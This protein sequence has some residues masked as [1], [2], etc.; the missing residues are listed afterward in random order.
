VRGRVLAVQF[1][2][3]NLIG[4]LPMLFVGNLADVFGIPRVTVFVAAFV[5][6]F[7][8]MN[9]IWAIATYRDARQRHVP[10]DPQSTPTHLSS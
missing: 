1:T 8:L 2:L 4:I 5:A 6:F 7:A 9:L 10:S 3:S